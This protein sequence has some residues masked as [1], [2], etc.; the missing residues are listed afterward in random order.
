MLIDELNRKGDEELLFPISLEAPLV[1][2][3]QEGLLFIGTAVDYGDGIWILDPHLY[4]FENHSYTPVNISF[5][6]SANDEIRKL[7]N[8]DEVRTFAP[9]AGFNAG[10]IS[11]VPLAFPTRI[12]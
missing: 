7:S 5:K 8:S 11:G 9:S 3:L 10:I 6:V 4:S 2:F 1:S 12:H